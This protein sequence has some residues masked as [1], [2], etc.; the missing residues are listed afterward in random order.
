[1]EEIDLTD[2]YSRGTSS[3]GMNGILNPIEEILYEH[4]D[5]KVDHFFGYIIC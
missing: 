2:I 3:P 4:L 1:L 5:F